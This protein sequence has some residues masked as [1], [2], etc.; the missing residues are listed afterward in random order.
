MPVWALQRELHYAYVTIK[1]HWAN[2]MHILWILLLYFIEYW[3]FSISFNAFGLKSVLILNSLPT[4]NCYVQRTDPNFHHLY[5]N[6]FNIFP[7]KPVTT[8]WFVKNTCFCFSAD[9][10]FYLRALKN[11][12]CSRK[13]FTMYT[14]VVINRPNASAAENKINNYLREFR[15]CNP[16]ALQSMLYLNKP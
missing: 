1:K 7:V 16:T 10:K 8:L 2:E 15:P 13:E 11:C 5:I 9:P 6:L 3:F 4:I 14:T 12:S